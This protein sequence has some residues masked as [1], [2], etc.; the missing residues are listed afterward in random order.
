MRDTILS[1]LD[2]PLE[3]A[4]VVDHLGKWLFHCH[5]LGHH[6]SGMTTW[7]NLT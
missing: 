7:I 3:N 6:A 2:E 4:F 1:Y 5:M